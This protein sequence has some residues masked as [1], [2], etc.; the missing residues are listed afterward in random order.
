MVI[1]NITFMFYMNMTQVSTSLDGKETVEEKVRYIF[2]GEDLD[3]FIS[4]SNQLGNKG[5]IK[6]GSND[7]VEFTIEVSSSRTY[8]NINLT[9]NPDW[10]KQSI[11]NSC[12]LKNNG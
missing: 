11:F 6:L 5:L 3:T 1:N 9:K 2:N 4:F 12:L 10:K 8:L 7:F